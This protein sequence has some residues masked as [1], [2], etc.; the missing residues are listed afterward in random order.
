MSSIPSLVIN[1]AGTSTETARLIGTWLLIAMNDR[2]DS[3]E[4]RSVRLIT[5]PTPRHGAGR[6]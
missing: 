6:V 3:R 1:L 2:Q 4:R 5:A